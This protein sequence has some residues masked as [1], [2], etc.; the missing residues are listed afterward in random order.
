[1]PVRPSMAVADEDHRLSRDTMET[2]VISAAAG[3]DALS[4]VYLCRRPG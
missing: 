4:G 1:M 2:M 3:T